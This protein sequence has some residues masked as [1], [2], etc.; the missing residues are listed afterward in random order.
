MGT[1]QRAASRSSEARREAEPGLRR[2]QVS[3]DS[4]PISRVSFIKTSTPWCS[5]AQTSVPLT[6]G[7][8][9]TDLSSLA[10]EIFG[11][12]VSDKLRD[13]VG[14]DVGMVAAVVK[15][16]FTGN[17][18]DIADAAGQKS[19]EQTESRPSADPDPSPFE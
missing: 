3:R 9:C 6:P 5:K 7:E 11:T 19:L 14:Y 16:G 15:S 18:P 17:V 8:H 1:T 2:N 12:R 4:L 10:C 13:L